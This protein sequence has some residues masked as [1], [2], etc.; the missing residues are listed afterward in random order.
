MALQIDNRQQRYLY[1]TLVTTTISLVASFGIFLKSG[2]WFKL[3]S[4]LFRLS[5]RSTPGRGADF[6]KGRGFNLF[7][8][9]RPAMFFELDPLS[10][11]PW[12]IS[13]YKLGRSVVTASA[14]GH[15]LRHSGLV[16]ELS[17]FFLKV[18]D[19]EPMQC[20]LCIH[21]SVYISY[22]Q[23]RFVLVHLCTC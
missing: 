11:L 15:W 7:I 1:N 17:L 23:Y 13:D 12:R 3:A 9:D 6:A 18:R 2:H 10:N 5:V 19:V 14:P 4:C 16:C 8:A 20:L 21:V 22:G